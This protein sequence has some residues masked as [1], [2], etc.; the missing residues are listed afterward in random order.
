MND[1]WKMFNFFTGDDV[2]PVDTKS[3][4]ISNIVTC[5]NLPPD[6]VP[7]F[8]KYASLIEIGNNKSD[9]VMLLDGQND[10]ICE[11]EYF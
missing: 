10:E 11:T 1:I 3:A 8:D 7:I 4:S 6:F 2:L 5:H 9:S